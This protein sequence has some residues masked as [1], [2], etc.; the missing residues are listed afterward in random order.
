MYT[1]ALSQ[2]S[3]ALVSSG[4]LF[5]GLGHILFVSLRAGVLW[6]FIDEVQS[7]FCRD[8]NVLLTAQ[9][10]MRKCQKELVLITTTVKIIIHYLW[11]PVS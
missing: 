2:N 9:G 4:V 10:G 5:L 6:C 3:T 7:R 11:R 1:L 8:S